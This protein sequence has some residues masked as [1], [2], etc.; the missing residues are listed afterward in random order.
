MRKTVS[1]AITAVVLLTVFASSAD[2]ATTTKKSS[3]LSW[4]KALRVWIE[5]KLSPPLPGPEPT[6]VAAS[7]DIK[8]STT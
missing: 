6:P 4:P 8:R 7:S 2:A 5:G 1:V 3:T